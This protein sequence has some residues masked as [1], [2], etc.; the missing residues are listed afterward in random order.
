LVSISVLISEHGL[1]FDISYQVNPILHVDLHGSFTSLTKLN[2]GGAIAVGVNRSLDL[3]TL[4]SLQVN[5]TI[6][7][8]LT[9]GYTGGDPSATFQGGFVFQSIQCNIPTV[10]LDAHGVALQNIDDTLWNQVMDIINK[11]LKDADHWLTWVH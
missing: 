4:G 10:T 1:T 5:T 7:G 8:T 11:L 3:G 2:A 9:V 6:N